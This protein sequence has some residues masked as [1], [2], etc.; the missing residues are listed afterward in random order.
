MEK[1]KVFSKTWS[2][3]Q[4]TLK[5]NKYR[6]HICMQSPSSHLPENQG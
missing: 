6:Y 3:K 5:T 1:R 4:V 2:I